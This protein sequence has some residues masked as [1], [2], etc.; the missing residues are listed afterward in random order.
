MV[1]PQIVNLIVVGSTPTPTPAVK[2]AAESPD[3]GE[4]FA[5]LLGRFGCVYTFSR[6]GG[7]VRG[8]AGCRYRQGPLD[9]KRD[10]QT[11]DAN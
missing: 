11:D 5:G 8:P 1:E 4:R 2:A 6:S 9:K 3:G 10:T 7:T